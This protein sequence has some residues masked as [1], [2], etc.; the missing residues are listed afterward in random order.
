MFTARKILECVCGILLFSVLFID[1]WKYAFS[2]FDFEG[3][4]S[5]EEDTMDFIIRLV[6]VI[7]MLFIIILVCRLRSPTVRNRHTKKRTFN[8]LIETLEKSKKTKYSQ[9]TKKS[10]DTRPTVSECIIC[11]VEYQEND[12][13]TQL[14]CHKNHLF[15]RNCLKQ[16]LVTYK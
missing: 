4:E 13:V 16:Y 14:K 7:N 12:F 1:L 8:K 6:Q 11:L 10:E 5:D 2:G 9:L 15:H 3:I